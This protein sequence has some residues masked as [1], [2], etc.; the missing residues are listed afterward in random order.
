MDT[1]NGYEIGLQ[2]F[3]NYMIQS[4]RDSF[5]GTFEL[6]LMAQQPLIGQGLLIIEASQSHSEAPHSV[7]LFFPA[8]CSDLCLTTHNTHKR[9]ISIPPTGFEPAIPGSE[10]PQTLWTNMELG[11]WQPENAKSLSLSYLETASFREPGCVIP[12]DD[13]VSAVSAIRVYCTGLEKCS[14]YCVLPVYCVFSLYT[15]LFRTVTD[16]DFPVLLIGTESER[17]PTRLSEN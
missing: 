2:S 15:D 14:R 4:A 1:Q 5:S 9:Q 10:R 12:F 3:L 7:G 6:F 8:R 16:T 17:R 11:S 13:T